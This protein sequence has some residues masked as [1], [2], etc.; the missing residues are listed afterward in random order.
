MGKNDV[1]NMVRT[2]TLQAVVLHEN[3]L[4]DKK[5]LTSKKLLE[6]KLLELFC[7]AVQ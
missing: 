6:V 7:F 4:Y 2:S 1:T 3:I 5:V